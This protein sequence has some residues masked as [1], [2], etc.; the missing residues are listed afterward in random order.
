MTRHAGLCQRQAAIR[1]SRRA[2][3]GGRTHV[4]SIGSRW[5]IHLINAVLQIRQ[6]PHALQGFGHRT[7]D[8]Y[9]RLFR[10]FRSISDANNCVNG[11][12]LG[13]KR[14]EMAGLLDD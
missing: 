12:F 7:A 3:T 2:C 13:P 1:R 6:K 10:Q 9:A 11:G 4:R 14:E 8:F 5:L